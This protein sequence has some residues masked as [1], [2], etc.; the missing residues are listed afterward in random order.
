L[1]SLYILNA[2]R[3]HGVPRVTLMRMAANVAIDYL[4]GA[5]PLLGDVF[6][7][8]WK[9]NLRNVNLLRQHLRTSPAEERRSRVGDWLF[10]AGLILGLIAILIGSLGLAYFIV[11]SLADLVTHR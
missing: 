11:L 5:I 4:F 7:V 1:V 6:D 3:Q 9:A 10:M 8:Y 2:A